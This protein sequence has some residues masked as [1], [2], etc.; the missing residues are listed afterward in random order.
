LTGDF[1]DTQFPALH[2]EHLVEAR[3]FADRSDLLRAVAPTE[4]AVI[5][6]VGVAL[7]HFSEILIEVCRPERFVAIDSF[8]LD[9]FSDLW[10]RPTSEVFGDR[11]HEELYRSRL[12]KY[13]KRMVVERG[14]SWEVLGRYPE[15]YF[16]LVYIDAAHDF[17]SVKK[18]A[19]IAA[20]RTKRSGI[21]IFN[22]YIMYDHVAQQDYG[23]VQNVNALV[24]ESGWKVLGLGLH[25]QMFCDIAV[26]RPAQ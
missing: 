1:T 10:G 15:E 14:L 17:E 4:G 8:E 18:D 12:A 9:Q 23:V 6:E 13:E 24:V 21:L 16:D 26:R 7:G 5:A 3:L 20:S 19:N 25:P 2:E 11:T 22:D